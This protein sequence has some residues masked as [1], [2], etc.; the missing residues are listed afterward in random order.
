MFHFWINVCFHCICKKNLSFCTHWV[1]PHFSLHKY[2]FPL[3]MQHTCMKGADWHHC[4]VSGAPDSPASNFDWAPNYQ[5]A[6]PWATDKCLY[7]ETS[8]CFV[9]KIVFNFVCSKLFIRFLW[10]NTEEPWLKLLSVPSC[11]LRKWYY[12]LGS[13]L[14]IASFWGCGEGAFRK[15]ETVKVRWWNPRTWRWRS[16]T[17]N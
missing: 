15:W 10:T 7:S 3:L 16:Y 11:F 5:I 14:V 13:S 12:C 8:V 6:V 9:W 1:N 2:C 17:N 4:T